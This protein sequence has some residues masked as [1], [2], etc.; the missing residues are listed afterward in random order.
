MRSSPMR[1]AG[2]PS[3][4]AR[5]RSHRSS[6]RCARAPASEVAGLLA[7]QGIE[8][9]LVPITT[10]GDEGAAASEHPVGLK[11]L[12]IDAILEALEAGTIEVAVHSAKDLPAEEDDG[13]FTIAAVP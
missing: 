8:T 7:A 6:P 5:E 13:A 12:F 4:A 1:S 10:S 2:S 9:K 3:A 11:G